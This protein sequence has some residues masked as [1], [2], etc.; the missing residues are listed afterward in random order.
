M[1]QTKEAQKRIQLAINSG[2]IGQAV[3]L[4]HIFFEQS[5]HSVESLVWLAHR[6]LKCSLFRLAVTAMER[7]VALAP[8]DFR[9]RLQ[10]ATAMVHA[11]QY[12]TAIQQCLLLQDELYNNPDAMNLLAYCYSALGDFSAAEPLYHAILKVDPSHSYA[13]AGLSKCRKFGEG[14]SGL[15]EKFLSALK[16]SMDPVAQARIHHAVA[17]ILNDCGEYDDAWEAASKANQIMRKVGDSEQ[18]DRIRRF[19]DNILATYKEREWPVASIAA[20]AQHLLIVGMP[21]SGTTLVEQV[22][23]SCESYYPGGEVP[24]IE[25]AQQHLR[26]VSNSPKEVSLDRAASAYLAYFNE[27]GDVAGRRIIN[28]VP[29]NFLNVGFFKQLFP[30]GKVIYVK[31]DVRDIAASVYFEHFS[32]ALSYTTDVADTLAVHQQCARVMDFW[33]EQFPKDVF[34]IEYE[35]LV[36][37]YN[38]Q[39][40]IIAEKLGIENEAIG[41]HTAT[42][43]AVETPS[44]WQVRQGIY[45]SS[46]GRWKRYSK[47]ISE[48]QALSR[49]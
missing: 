33:A 27:F 16:A 39:V 17:K 5:P 7:A 40:G 35:L 6:A 3:A 8:G 28:K 25:F 15:C 31:R 18:P 22:L 46:I 14:S 23:A 11:R 2:D 41:V 1:L 42:Q 9:V 49:L 24:A 48:F 10:L 30:A 32:E 19:V 21:R 38:S 47:L 26:Q 13:I 36:Q 29:G 20:D 34:C 44:H 45:Q 4:M 43:N 12:E 37:D